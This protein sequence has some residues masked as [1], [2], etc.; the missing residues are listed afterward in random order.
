MNRNLNC[1]FK[2]HCSPN[3]GNYSASPDGIWDANN[4]LN[5]FA[6]AKQDTTRTPRASDGVICSICYNPGSDFFPLRQL[7]NPRLFV[8][9]ARN[10]A[11]QFIV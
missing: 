8:I 2:L 1:R 3:A 11:G 6:F 10:N 9:L 4:A 5:F 7:L